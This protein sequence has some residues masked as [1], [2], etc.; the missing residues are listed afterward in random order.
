MSINSIPIDIL[1][2]YDDLYVL[3]Q[4]SKSF[5]KCRKAHIKSI[6]F[7]LTKNIDLR[8]KEFIYNNAI[9]IIVDN[10]VDIVECRKQITHLTF[11]SSFNE[12]I[13]SG[14]IP[15]SVTHLTFGF[16][17]NQPLIMG[18]IPASVIYL[19]FGWDFNQPLTIG[20]I[21]V[22]VTHLTFGDCFNQP[23]TIGIIPALWILLY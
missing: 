15:I 13:P 22:S 21:P 16:F 20:V 12:P 18:V 9:K 11:E 10:L 2:K 5:K 19:T 14:I 7:D 8:K 23:L 4:L 3:W 1:R 6:C 17:F